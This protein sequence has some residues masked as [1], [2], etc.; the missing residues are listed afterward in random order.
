MMKNKKLRRQ[1]LDRFFEDLKRLNLRL[2]KQG[3]VKEVRE[4]LG[5][6]MQDLADRLGTIKQRIEK[7]EKDEV[8]AKTTLETMKKTAEAL[9]CEFVYFFVPKKGLEE[10]LRYQALKS[11]ERI[12]KQVN[13][14]MG[15][16]SQSVSRQS[17]K[18]LSESLAQEMLQKEDRR[19][20]RQ[21]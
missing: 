17:E 13:K 4:S 7:I 19:I 16:E 1:Q 6:S 5:L 21:K 8:A 10:T 12:L 2:P 9:D 14:T 3:W 20:W 15:L 11:A 18:K